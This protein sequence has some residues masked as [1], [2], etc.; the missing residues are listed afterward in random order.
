M[1]MSYQPFDLN[2]LT[3]EQRAIVETPLPNFGHLRDYVDRLH[4]ITGP[5]GMCMCG[6]DGITCA[7]RLSRVSAD[8]RD[9]QINFTP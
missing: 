9:A 3:P 7:E 8:I 2:Q 4:I 1:M 5:N 6:E